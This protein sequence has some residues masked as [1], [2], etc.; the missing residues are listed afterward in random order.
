M[1]ANSNANTHLRP[2][3]LFVC[4]AMAAVGAVFPIAAN[5]FAS[6]I[7][8]HDIVSDTISDLGR[9][10]HKWIM[11]LGFYVNA[12]G[13]LAMALGC[14]HAH[15]G[16]IGW[17]LGIIC[18]S[19]L[20]LVTVLIGV[21]DEFGRQIDA[22]EGLSVH[23]RLTFF[24]GPLYFLGPL[25]MFGAIR[26]ISQTSGWLFLSAAVLWVVFAGAFKLAP[27]SVDGLLEK[28]AVAATL[29]WTIPLAKYLYDQGRD[30]AR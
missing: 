22:E 14:A 17:S 13:L 19:L 20:A 4:A 23:T 3:L 28:M 15:A 18:L 1:N 29:L 8:E 10:P 2:E 25:F 27:N 16:R 24:L 7:A 6:F 21:W 9:G 30:A 12:A 5:I 11:D 26:K